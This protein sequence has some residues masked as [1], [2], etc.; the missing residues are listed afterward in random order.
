MENAIR[1]F[2]SRARVETEEIMSQSEEEE[3]VRL[4]NKAYC[5][6]KGEEII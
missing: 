3:A 2:C 5:D 6:H 1:H 4:G